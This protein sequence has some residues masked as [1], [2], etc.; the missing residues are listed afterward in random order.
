MFGAPEESRTPD[1]RLKRAL[2]YQ[3]SYR[4]IFPISPGSVWLSQMEFIQSFRFARLVHLFNLYCSSP[5]EGY[6]FSGS[7]S[8]VGVYQ[9]AA[10]LIGLPALLT[11][12]QLDLS[13]FCAGFS[14]EGMTLL[15][16]HKMEI[17][18]GLRRLS[19]SPRT[20]DRSK[21]A[22]TGMVEREGN[23]PSSCGFSDR[24]SDLISYRSIEKG[25]SLCN[26][27][28]PN[29]QHGIWSMAA[30]VGLE[31]T[32]RSSRPTV[33]KTAPRTYW[34]QFRHVGE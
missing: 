24:R 2:L 4:R 11:A 23:D 3:L 33:F 20:L 7:I 19:V 8:P 17:C 31:P 18:V 21:I 22:I 12:A 1:P 26:S 30:E 15:C 5:L 32:G 34:G 27:P 9:P 25:G 10:L 13:R 16:R 28:S 14:P 29:I 6:T